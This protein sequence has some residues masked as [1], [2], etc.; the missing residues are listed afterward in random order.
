ME[1]DMNRT[2][3]TPA[4]ET[5]LKDG[6]SVTLGDIVKMALVSDIPNEKISGEVNDKR[7]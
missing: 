1:I 6:K 4:G 7:R 3:V 5:I 2:F